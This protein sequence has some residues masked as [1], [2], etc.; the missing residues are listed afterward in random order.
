MDI[1]ESCATSRCFFKGY[2]FSMK[3]DLKMLLE[4]L[5]S[6]PY[7]GLHLFKRKKIFCVNNTLKRVK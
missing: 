1:F 2:D 5:C 6:F 4:I 7:S 3:V